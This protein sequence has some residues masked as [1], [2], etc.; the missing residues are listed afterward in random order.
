LATQVCNACPKRARESGR[1]ALR[2][3]SKFG[4]GATHTPA[5]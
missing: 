1:E 5:A 2:V 3:A 4:G